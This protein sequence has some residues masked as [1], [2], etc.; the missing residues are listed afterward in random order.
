LKKR[1]KKLLSI[2]EIKARL[3]QQARAALQQGNV[4]AGEQLA[5]HILTHLEIPADA[6]I[7]GV[8]PL[9]AEMD[10]RP[11]LHTLYARGHR[12]VLPK[13]PPRGHPLTFLTW[14]PGCAMRPERFGTFCPEGEEATP[15]LLFVPLL[16][17]DRV[18]RRLGYGGGYYDRTLAALPGRPAIGFAYAAQEIEAVPAEPHDRLLNAIAT[19]REFIHIRR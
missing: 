18:G 17:F 6:T 14:Y 11:L 1:S 5:Q 16:A 3:R 13:T 12:I 4:E 19:E 10:L 9:G 8:W 7:A 2:A 15:D